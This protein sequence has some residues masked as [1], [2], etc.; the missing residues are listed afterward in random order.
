MNYLKKPKIIE[1]IGMLLILLSW[2]FGFWNVE[3]YTKE[4]DALNNELKNKSDYYQNIIDRTIIKLDTEITSTISGIDDKRVYWRTEEE[5]SNLQTDKSIRIFLL[6]EIN[7]L[8]EL[9]WENWHV[10]KKWLDVIVAKIDYINDVYRTLEKYSKQNNIVLTDKV[11]SIYNLANKHMDKV[12]SFMDPILTVH[13][14]FPYLIRKNFNHIDAMIIDQEIS[15]EGIAILINNEQD[16]LAKKI[17]DKKRINL[18]LSFFI[19]GTLF[20]I[21]SKLLEVHFEN[22]G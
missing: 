19:L 17:D 3:K 20:I 1:A 9:S 16:I 12:F 8:D 10:R 14:G 6:N 21:F 7:D 11:T 15:I 5:R 22:K 4:I 13:Y 18:F 2:G